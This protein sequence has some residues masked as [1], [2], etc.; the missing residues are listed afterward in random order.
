M[1]IFQKELWKLASYRFYT[2]LQ[3]T[4]KYIHIIILP[5]DHKP[6]KMEIYQQVDIV[7]LYILFGFQHAEGFTNFLNKHIPPYYFLQSGKPSGPSTTHP[8]QNLIMG[9]LGWLCWLS[10]QLFIFVQVMIPQICDFK[11]H[12]SLCTYNT[13]PAWDFP[14]LSFPPLLLNSLSQK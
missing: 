10:I 11:P 7:W 6:S 4:H 12:I 14:P 5:I 9:A 8:L 3:Q 13:E 2:Q 1:N